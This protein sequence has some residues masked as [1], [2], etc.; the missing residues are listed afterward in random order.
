MALI[1][2]TLMD[3]Q[4]SSN[5]IVEHPDYDSEEWRL[6][7]ELAACFRLM[8]KFK[9]TDITATHACVSIPGTN[10]LLFNPFGL[11]MEEV[12]ATSLVKMDYQGNI[13]SRN[14]DPPVSA[15]FAIHSV[16][17]KARPDI[18]CSIHT[19]TKAGTGVASLECGLLPINQMSLIFYDRIAYNK[20]KYIMDVD[21]CGQLVSDLG[22]K[23]AMIMLNHGLLTG[24]SSVA[25]AFVLMYFLDKAC[26]I[27]LD[28]MATS[29]KLVTPPP[30]VCEEAAKRWMDIDGY[31][32]GEV[33]WRALVRQLDDEDDSYKS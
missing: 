4:E 19:H 15:G 22:D 6:R 28:A 18:V 8:V 7:V 5:R 20:Y 12:T 31:S 26:E 30:D 23:N 24:G 1:D 9:M 29:E 13:L 10:H 21:E 25:E 3:K 11:L 27:Q 32:F 14:A 33:E 16:I 17:H 2:S